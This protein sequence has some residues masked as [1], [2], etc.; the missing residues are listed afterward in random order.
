MILLT[1]VPETFTSEINFNVKLSLEVSLTYLI[2]KK[3]NINWFWFLNG[4]MTAKSKYR[5]ESSYRGVRTC[6]KK[7]V[8]LLS[9]AP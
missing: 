4:V 8:I 1:K 2:L 3:I 5:V 9:E 6:L 7:A